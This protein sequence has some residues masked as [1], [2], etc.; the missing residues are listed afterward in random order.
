MA[1][2]TET[3]F[4]EKLLKLKSLVFQFD[5][6]FD[7]EKTQLLNELITFGSFKQQSFQQFHQLLISI[8]WVQLLKLI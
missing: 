7:K 3:D 4:T 1:N 5:L 2:I 6:S 8:G